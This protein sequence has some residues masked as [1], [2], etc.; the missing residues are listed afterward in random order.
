VQQSRFRVRNATSAAAW[1]PIWLLE[2]H[3]GCDFQK[4]GALT[5]KF[6]RP[7]GSEPETCGVG[8]RRSH[9][10]AGVRNCA[11]TLGLP[12]AGVRTG[13][14]ASALRGSPFASPKSRKVIF[15]EL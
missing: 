4:Q 8:F 1:P 11:L 6:V 5:S 3:F 9:G 15:M 14:Q 12:F 7:P 10:F 13:S 2:G